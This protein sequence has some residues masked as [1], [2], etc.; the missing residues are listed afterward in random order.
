MSDSD[1]L[2]VFFEKIH[3]VGTGTRLFF[4]KKI[5]DAA[6]VAEE[7]YKDLVD[8]LTRVQQKLTEM[9]GLAVSQE[10]EITSLISHLAEMGSLNE[11]LRGDTSSLLEEQNILEEK[12]V[13]MTKIASANANSAE[14]WKATE[15]ALQAEFV[16]LDKQYKELFAA[17]AS[18][19]ADR[20]VLAADLF[21][22][23]TAHLADNEQA[24]TFREQYLCRE[25]EIDI[26]RKELATQR[27]EIECYVR[28]RDA[29]Y[30]ALVAEVE[31]LNTLSAKLEEEKKTAELVSRQN[32]AEVF[33][34][35]H[36]RVGGMLAKICTDLRLDLKTG[37]AYRGVSHPDFAILVNSSYVFFNAVSPI[38]PD[39]VSSFVRVVAEEA[40]KLFEA[41][42]E[43]G[44]RGEAY[45]VV[46]NAVAA[47]LTEFVF[48]SDRCTV[49]VVTPEALQAIVRTL[50]RIEEYEFSRQITPF[51]LDQICR[52]IGELSHMMKRKIVLD[53][54]FSNEMLEIL[55]KTENLPTD[56]AVDATRYENAMRV[57]PPV[58]R[59]I[60]MLTIPSLSAKV[61]K[62]EK[63]MLAR[64]TV[65][66]KCAS[67]DESSEE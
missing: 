42:K 34:G 32:L 36:V 39:D 6:I 8:N 23:R 5:C 7:E 30:S 35:H 58:E 18:L 48:E 20:D 51:E 53:M 54:Y 41:A 14:Q 64:A 50:R 3:G 19:S 61:R 22:E 46:P 13:E 28:E 16:A 33:E 2:G 1:N 38:S 25:A 66:S 29:K 17:H 31:H 43:D 63:A 47:D 60:T 9:E 12:L 10:A 55:Q 44:V 45:L 11:A 21:A 4:W 40:T 56:V 27:A 67:L 62:L 24:R 49:F 15:G 65:E 26:L 37:E 57:N 59:D 52:F